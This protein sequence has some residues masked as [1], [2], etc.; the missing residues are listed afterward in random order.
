M[1]FLLVDRITDFQSGKLVKGLKHISASEPYLSYSPETKQTIFLPALL[2]E[3]VGQMTA[4]AVMDAFD[5]QVRPIAGIVSQVNIFGEAKVGDILEMSAEI[6]ALDDQA[7]EYSGQAKVS[8]QT[9]FEI[10][11]AIGPMIN[12]AEVNERAEV[13][14]Q[15]AMISSDLASSNIEDYQSAEPWDLFPDLALN[16][17]IN[18]QGCFDRVLKL[19]QSEECIAEKL[20]S[21]SAPYFKDH[22][23]KKPV[24]PLTILLNCKIEFAKLYL[25]NFF[26][27]EQFRVR[28]AR[29]IKMSQFVLPGQVVKTVM[30]TRSSEKAFIFQFKSFVANQRVC[31]CEVVFE[32]D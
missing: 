29:K 12:M 2:G 8:G 24:L 25:K 13:L 11:R 30:K 21:L 32:R 19:S 15:F 27:T 5:F 7:V 16:T 14:Q 6:H 31:V 17:G 9:I 10:E 23:P 20:V 4:W 1:S 3:A 18:P 22:F 26:S 28:C